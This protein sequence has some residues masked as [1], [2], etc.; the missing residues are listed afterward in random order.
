[1]NNEENM[2]ARN[3]KQKAVKLARRTEEICEQEQQSKKS[4]KGKQ[5]TKAE[6]KNTN[7]DQIQIEVWRE[8]NR[9][10]KKENSKRK[11]PSERY[12][13]KAN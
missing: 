9:I 10:V 4:R 11:I 8:R 2:R 6:N 5:Q 7:N 12:Q 1:M 13:A 3:A